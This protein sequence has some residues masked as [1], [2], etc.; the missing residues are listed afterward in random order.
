MVHYDRKAVDDDGQ[1]A[2]GFGPEPGFRLIDAA[3]EA[4]CRCDLDR[5]L[6]TLGKGVGGVLDCGPSV[7]PPKRVETTGKKN[8]RSQLFAW[9]EVQTRLPPPESTALCAQV[10]HHIC[11]QSEARDAGKSAKDRLEKPTP[12]ANQD[13]A[14]RCTLGIQQRTRDL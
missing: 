13:A 5:L 12:A 2:V 9:A 6:A 10:Q 1:Y 11:T 7:G 4:K 3:E 8:Q 14:R